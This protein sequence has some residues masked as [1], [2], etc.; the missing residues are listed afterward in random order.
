[1]KGHEKILNT[2]ICL[3]IMARNN[4]EALKKMSQGASFADILEIRLDVMETFDLKELIQR[5]PKPVI[6]TYRSKREGGSGLSRYETRIRHLL[7]AIEFGADFVD[8]EY[9]MPQI[10]RQEVFQAK[11]A[12]KLIISI[13]FLTKTPSVKKLEDLFKKMA[14]TGAD[15]I[16][17]VPYARSPEDN[18]RVLGLIPLAQRIGINIIAFCMGPAGRLSR[19]FTL[20]MGGFLTFASLEE[21]QESASG[22]IPIIEMRKIMDMISSTH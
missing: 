2:M 20:I 7:M 3:P 14:V 12:S 4:A 17:I 10:Y 19:I 21:G 9:N 8:I 22:Q 16:K 5:A 1:M 13:H 6:V 11:G 15:I 18:L